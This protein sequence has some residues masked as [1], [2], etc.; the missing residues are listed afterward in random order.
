MLKLLTPI[1]GNIA[2]KG[3]P[4]GS[5]NRFFSQSFT[6]KPHSP[7][8]L[9]K[10]LKELQQRKIN[11]EITTLKKGTTLTGLNMH[12]DEHLLYEAYP[13]YSKETLQRLSTQEK[14]FFHQMSKDFYARF[15]NFILKDDI[16]CVKTTTTDTKLPFFYIHRDMTQ[17]GKVEKVA[18]ILPLEDT[19]FSFKPKI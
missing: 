17:L 4:K 1:V 10:Q 6:N 8:Y 14:S 2:F 15:A 11:A 16:Q 18:N 19:E 5:S 3:A 7:S 12:F 13:L 9:E